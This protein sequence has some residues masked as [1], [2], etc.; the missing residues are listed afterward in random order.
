M[1]RTLYQQD[2]YTIHIVIRK[3]MA[4]LN[5]NK[6][7]AKGWGPSPPREIKKRKQAELQQLQLNSSH[8]S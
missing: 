4:H 6:L 8:T 5:H 3:D 7:L 1:L 2:F